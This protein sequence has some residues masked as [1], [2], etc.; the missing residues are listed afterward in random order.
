MHRKRL[1]I[2]AAKVLFG[3]AIAESNAAEGIAKGGKTCHG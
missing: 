3:H 1:G 2:G